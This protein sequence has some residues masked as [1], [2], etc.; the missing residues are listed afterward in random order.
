[1]RISQLNYVESSRAIGAKDRRIMA[2]HILPNALPPILVH[3]AFGVAGAILI[4]ST[5]SFLQ[6]GVPPESVSW[7]SI[8]NL[9]LTNNI[10]DKLW[11][12]IAPGLAIFIM[13][14]ALN[15][16]GES[17]QQAFNPKQHD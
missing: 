3:A 7:G 15:I 12:I 14:M 1:M 13:V 6:V 2:S 17:I 10:T 8:L 5:L 4:E 11:L 16:L 9:A